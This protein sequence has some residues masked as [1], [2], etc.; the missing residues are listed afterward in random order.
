M[1]K[2]AL[3]MHQ[4]SPLCAR[5]GIIRG[6]ITH[7]RK[8]EIPDY[9]ANSTRGRCKLHFRA[10]KRYRSFEAINVCYP[11]ALNVYN[12]RVVREKESEIS[13]RLISNCKMCYEK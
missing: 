6:I 4:H 7:C 3:L 13:K 8:N 9:Y 10:I 12:A 5:R 11:L 1:V 2:R